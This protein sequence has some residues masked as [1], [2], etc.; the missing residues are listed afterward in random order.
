VESMNTRFTCLVRWC[1]NCVEFQW[2]RIHNKLRLVDLN[3]WSVVSC[4]RM[5][6]ICAKVGIPRPLKEPCSCAWSDS[7]AYKWSTRQHIYSTTQASQTLMLARFSSIYS[8]NYYEA[9]RSA[10]LHY[11]PWRHIKQK[12]LP[13]GR[14]SHLIAISHPSNPR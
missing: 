8:M 9:L 5:I 13:P 3:N 12:E 2:M 4:S 1:V 10:A 7:L 14:S 6:R 11:K